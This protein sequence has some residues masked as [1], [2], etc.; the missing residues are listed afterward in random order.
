MS[1][2]DIDK[3]V[4]FRN[5][6]DVKEVKF[7]MRLKRENNKD[8]LAFL[9]IDY[10]LSEWLVER[11]L[12]G[13]H[14]DDARIDGDYDIINVP[15]RPTLNWDKPLWTKL[16][17]YKVVRF[18][19]TGSPIYPYKATIKRDD[20]LYEIA[21]MLNGHC[22]DSENS[23][24][25]DLENYEPEQPK[26]SWDKPIRYISTGDICVFMGDSTIP[27]EDFRYK[28]LL[29]FKNKK[30]GGLW[31]GNFTE[32]DERY[33]ENFEPDGFYILTNAVLFKQAK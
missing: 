26:F 7:L 12:N 6:P 5:R 23:H 25:F 29:V 27:N 15:E 31:A 1:E 9:A 14:Y 4:M 16:G 32:D 8:A 19:D 2:I 21:Y 11:P 3:P 28:K 22:L 10:K 17:H 24:D 33:L 30:G 13:R 18:V 20:G